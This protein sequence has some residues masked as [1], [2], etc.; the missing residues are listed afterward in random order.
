MCTF[1]SWIEERNL[2]V[3]VEEQ[4]P[5]DI[6]STHQA[7]SEKLCKVLRLF[8]LEAR[9]IDG[10]KYPS[11]TIRNLL[12]GLNR[13]LLKNK[14]DFSILD[15]NDVRFRELHLTM[16]SVSSKLHRAGIGI[17]RKHAE[18]I[19]VEM[20]NLFWE[21]GS[22]GTSSPVVFQH[23]VFFYVGLQFVLCGVQEQHDLQVKQLARYPH[24]CS[25]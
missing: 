13:E 9:K 2:Q 18:V 11:G 1:Q 15:R 21:K 17:S 8:V 22:L 20:E 6:L 23:T 7:D 10:E 19:S 14:A 25:V 5:L 4:I 24:D 3:S 12:S 16:D